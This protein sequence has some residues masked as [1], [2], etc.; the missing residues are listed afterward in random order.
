[1]NVYVE[2]NFVLE[3]ALQQE[4]SHRCNEIIRLASVGQITL[5]VPAFSLAEPHQAITAKA[6]A[7][8]T[9]GGGSPVL[10]HLEANRPGQSCFLNRNSRDFDDP[11]IRDKLDGLNCKFFP[12]F[13]P[14]LVYVTSR[15]RTA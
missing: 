15:I 2:S 3:H 9:A 4:E 10:S 1:M 5:V 14:A 8:F 12:N 11:D 7:R 6:K 13:I